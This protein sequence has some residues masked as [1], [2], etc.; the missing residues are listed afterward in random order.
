[1]LESKL[2]FAAIDIGSNAVRL[3]IKGIRPGETVDEMTKCVLL[4]ASPCDWARMAFGNGRIS[5]E[6]QKRL[7]RTIKSFRLL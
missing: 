7:M 2:N 1:M 5:Q 6:K 3:L 4:P